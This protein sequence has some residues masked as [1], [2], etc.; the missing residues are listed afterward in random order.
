MNLGEKLR[1]III[2]NVDNARPFFAI[3][4]AQNEDFTW[5]VQPVDEQPLI[6]NA[7]T[8]QEEADGN[9][10]TIGSLVLCI[11]IDQYSCF[12]T[13]IIDYDTWFV[14]T[15]T[16]ST[17]YSVNNSVIAGKRVVLLGEE[18]TVDEVKDIVDNIQ[19][20]GDTGVLVESKNIRIESPGDTDGL[21]RIKSDGDIE[22]LCKN[23]VSIQGDKVTQ[24][25]SNFISLNLML[26]D[27][28][29][30]LN[31][32]STAAGNPVPA[33]PLVANLIIAEAQ[34]NQNN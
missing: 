1:K 10:P 28:V 26:R 22:I 34:Y 7:Q 27:I 33:L 19:N 2:D 5:Q 30:T 4:V 23:R 9:A 3:V 29:K 18:K 16:S 15:E 32:L 12:I 8:F 21:I 20:N 31:T 17:M 14:N 13:E 6:Y 24:I 25:V 11:Y